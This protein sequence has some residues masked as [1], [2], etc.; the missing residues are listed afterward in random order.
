MIKKKAAVDQFKKLES[1]LK[2]RRQKIYYI[3]NEKNRKL[4]KF[5]IIPRAEKNVSKV[6]KIRLPCYYSS[7]GYI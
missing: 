2:D 6:P 1:I 7:K 3:F 4:I 5:N